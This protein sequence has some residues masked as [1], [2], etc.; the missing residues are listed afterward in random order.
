[1]FRLRPDRPIRSCRI[2]RWSESWF[3][4]LFLAGLASGLGGCQQDTLSTD[5]AGMFQPAVASAV[6][7][8]TQLAVLAAADFEIVDCVLPGRVSRLGR[9]LTFL[10]AR[11][12]VRTTGRDCAIRGGEY[13]AYDRANYATALQVWLPL[14]KQGDPEAQTYV[15][16]I[17]EK[18]LGGSPD[19][20][21]A[22]DWYRRAAEQGYASAQVS[23]GQLYERGLGVPK[24]MVAAL[25]LYRQASGLEE[26]FEIVPAAALQTLESAV[27]QSERAAARSGQQVETLEQELREARNEL[28]EL[29]KQAEAEQEDLEQ[30]RRR[31]AEQRQALAARSLEPAHR[32]DG[33]HTA[34]AR[35]VDLQQA[36]REAELA[37]RSEELDR[38]LA[39]IA[40]REAEHRRQV[41]AE[42]AAL[43]AARRELAEQRMSLDSDLRQ[44][45][46]QREALEGEHATFTRQVGTQRSELQKH[47]GE[48]EERE[49]ELARQSEELNRRVAEIAA[50]EAEHRERV[51]AQ[52][53]SL[54]T[55][56]R[57]LQAARRELAERR[58]SV[59]AE[60]RQLEAQ[61]ERLAENH[62]SQIRQVEGRQAEL[63][64][65]HAAL[66]ERE[67][68]LARQAEELNSRISE[69]RIKAAKVERQQDELAHGAP[70]L[71]HLG[72]PPEEELI[73]YGKYYAL[74][75]GNSEYQS[76]AA[77]PALRSPRVDAEAMSALLQQKYGYIVMPLIN[78]TRDRILGALNTLRATLK[79]ED[80]LLIYYAGHGFLDTDSG[81]GYWLP[82]DAKPHPD[83]ANWISTEDITD[84]LNSM[85]AKHVL[86]MADS[87]YSGSL[88]S[89]NNAPMGLGVPEEER[90]YWLKTIANK[91]ARMALTSGNLSPVLDGGG[92]QHSIFARALLEVLGT[93]DRV[94]EGWR[95]Y[96]R[97]SARVSDVAQVYG[98]RQ[99]PT[100]G[101]IK[102]EKYA[103]GDF[104][105]VRS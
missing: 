43:E 71:R 96:L 6:G 65:Q 55:A 80:N 45:E 64:E 10:S 90:S 70:Q 29:R 74:V 14:A 15:G 52:R 31:L 53:A 68:E 56:Q 33:E 2:R 57:E 105:F 102:S 22:A 30:A 39:E 100:Y 72:A 21:I 1:M 63:R 35:Q 101:P 76:S 38:Q 9:Q 92:G 98:L 93:N 83:T 94:M 47:R 37:R 77:L 8:T 42:G 79:E 67:A 91:P 81:R 86:V 103:G 50:R 58:A 4:P 62:S 60:S 5:E 104:L 54:E 73:N 48:L 24:D 66:E 61:R 19:Y 16:N 78:A 51:A 28:E 88:T 18:G 95:V 13:V 3:L 85:S 34:R 49:S 99:V 44:L 36:Q 17:Y 89:S 82:V 69:I 26:T 75:I 97:V 20:A 41:A 27:E 23:L 11:R 40:A 59:D 32:E 84:I 7:A 87:C 25:D 12:P 46:A